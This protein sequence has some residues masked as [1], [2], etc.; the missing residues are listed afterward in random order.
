MSSS[1]N[2]STSPKPITQLA[3]DGLQELIDTIP[4]LVVLDVRTPMEYS[5]LGH[6][7]NA[8]LLPIQELIERVGELD[9]TKPTAVICEH[10]VRSSDASH[11]MSQQGFNTLYNL[12]QG[13]A[14]WQGARVYGDHPTETLTVDA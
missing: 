5:H 1:E 9:K 8:T 14:A 4:E 10:G 6:I 7:P 11:W 3:N 12:V 2:S 13:M